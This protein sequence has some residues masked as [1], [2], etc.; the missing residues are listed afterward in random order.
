[1]V[2]IAVVALNLTAMRA[3][4]DIRSHTNN[5]G[6]AILAL[7]VLPMA[8]ILA[9]GLLIGRRQRGSRPFLLGFEAFGAAALVVYLALVGFFAEGSVMPY[10][11][12]VLNPLA[13]TIGLHIPVFYSVTAVMLGLPQLAFA[14]IGGVLSR[15][16]AIAESPFRTCS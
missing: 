5:H 6:V 14:L 2:V 8:N 9:V 11:Y 10:L 1:M 4:S 3:V 13:K 12:L 16:F 15:Q 7:G